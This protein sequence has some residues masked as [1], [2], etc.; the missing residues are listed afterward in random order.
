MVRNKMFIESMKHVSL[1]IHELHTHLNIGHKRE[2][3]KQRVSFAS[4]IWGRERR[5]AHSGGVPSSQKCEEPT[6]KFCPTEQ[7]F[8]TGKPFLEC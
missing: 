3:P 6:L 8:E 4:G 7:I 1:L 2:I 5:R